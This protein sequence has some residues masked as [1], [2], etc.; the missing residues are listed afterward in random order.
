MGCPRS[1]GVTIPGGVQGARGCCTEGY[2]SGVLV[3]GG[4]LDWVISEVFS[5]LSDS[6][7]LWERPQSAPG[8]MLD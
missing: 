8:F 1:G 2:G 3:V 5:S 7:V 6:M 4:Q